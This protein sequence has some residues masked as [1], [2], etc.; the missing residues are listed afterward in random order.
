MALRV[1]GCVANTQDD[2]LL[3][4]IVDRV[5]DDVRVADNRHLADVGDFARLRA[6]GKIGKHVDGALDPGDDAM[7]SGR[8]ARGEA[9]DASGS[10][11]GSLRM[12]ALC[13]ISNVAAEA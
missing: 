9:L 13:L 10:R 2:D 5:E 4:D 6:T 12:E 8:I 11:A 3:S 1:L 7:R